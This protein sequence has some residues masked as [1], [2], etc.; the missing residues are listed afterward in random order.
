MIK[1]GITEFKVSLPK[2]LARFIKDLVEKEIVISAEE[3][4]AYATRS[5][6]DQYGFSSFIGGKVKTSEPSGAKVSQPIAAKVEEKPVEATPSP[7]SAPV[8]EKA[9]SVK[10]ADI[11]DVEAAILD[12]F[13]SSAFMFSEELYIKHVFGMSQIGKKPFEK[14]EFMEGLE[15]LERKKMLEKHEKE[16]KI[17]WKVVG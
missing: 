10:K 8:V 12:A 16:G 2:A 3:F 14:G 15:N 11:S 7:V 9:P 5:M 4:I 17:F 1:E 13:G 6:A